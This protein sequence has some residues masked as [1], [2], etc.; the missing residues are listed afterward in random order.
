MK[1]LKHWYELLPEP[2]S[3][4]PDVVGILCPREALFKRAST[5][6][7]KYTLIVME[8]NGRTTGMQ[9]EDVGLNTWYDHERVLNDYRVG[10][11][12]PFFIGPM[13]KIPDRAFSD[14]AFTAVFYLAAAHW[15][16]PC[17]PRQQI[18]DRAKADAK[19]LTN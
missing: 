19:G 7:G 13:S 18:G 15:R 11:A 5:T 8:H 2:Y 16:S 6:D 14:P 4:D 12:Q 3:A 10:M 1:R 17:C 9:V